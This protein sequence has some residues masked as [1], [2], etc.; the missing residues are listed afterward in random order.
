MSAHVVARRFI[1]RHGDDWKGDL[2]PN[3]G[4]VFGQPIRIT[5]PVEFADE[6]ALLAYLGVGTADVA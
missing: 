3:L 4:A 5:I 6:A 1:V 2:V